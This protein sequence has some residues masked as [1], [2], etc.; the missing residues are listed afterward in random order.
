MQVDLDHPQPFKQSTKVQKK[1]IS[2]KVQ[3][4]KNAKNANMQKNA[5]M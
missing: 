1:Y 5:K 2:T 4:Y 3:K